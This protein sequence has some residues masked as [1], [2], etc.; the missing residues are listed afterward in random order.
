MIKEASHLAELARLGGADI[1]AW[2]G[3]NG[4]L[5]RQI[6]Q[7]YDPVGNKNLIKDINHLER[8][9]RAAT[10]WVKGLRALTYEERIQALN[11]SP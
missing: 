6:S 10:R 3:V 2:A 5:L 1:F 7:I 8:I 4:G 9:Q 11:C